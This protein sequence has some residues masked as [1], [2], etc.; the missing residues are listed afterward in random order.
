L[1]SEVDECKPL[2][3]FATI[4]SGLA[5]AAAMAG[6]AVARPAPAVSPLDAAGRIADEDDVFILYI[7]TRGAAH[8]RASSEAIRHVFLCFGKAG[9]AELQLHS[10]R[11]R[12]VARGGESSRRIRSA[13]P[14]CW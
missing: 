6:R 14:G 11:G 12:D 2:P 13:R 10:Q 5:A 7:C 1:S 8:D 3:P 4:L 9:G